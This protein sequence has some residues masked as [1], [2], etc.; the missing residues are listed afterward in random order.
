MHLRDMFLVNPNI[1]Q[2]WV[3]SGNIYPFLTYCGHEIELHKVEPVLL[4]DIENSSLSSSCEA[5]FFV[6]PLH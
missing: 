3:I 6:A 1:S 4:L 5:E 2:K